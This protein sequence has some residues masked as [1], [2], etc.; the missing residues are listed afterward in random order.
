MNRRFGRWWFAPL[1]ALALVLQPRLAPAQV[2]AGA[3]AAPDASRA[4]KFFDLAACAVSIMA[5][6]TG[7]GAV[8]AVL[9]CGKAAFT[10]WDR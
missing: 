9:T 1:L 8:I 2:E 3:D 4:E 5:I 10:W 7:V 6:S